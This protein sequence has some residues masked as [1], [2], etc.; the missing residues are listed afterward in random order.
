MIL[1]RDGR[2]GVAARPKTERGAVAL[3][4]LFERWHVDTG[5]HARA[6]SDRDTAA[7]G[8][9]LHVV[10]QVILLHLVRG[11]PG[12]TRVERGDQ[13]S[14]RAALQAGSRE[15]DSLDDVGSAPLR[16]LK[17]TSVDAPAHRAPHPLVLLLGT[18]GVVVV[19]LPV[20]VLEVVPDALHKGASARQEHRLLRRRGR[21]RRRCR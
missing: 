17:P 13:E 3:F 11:P 20:L 14:M 18:L 16:A 4:P 10:D 2:M 1:A 7:P 15:F 9:L 8:H 6:V 19:P 5:H 12:D 21:G